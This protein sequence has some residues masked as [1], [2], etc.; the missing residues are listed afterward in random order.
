MRFAIC[1]ARRHSVDELMEVRDKKREKRGG[2]RDKVYW[3][4][5]EKRL[6]NLKRI[7]AKYLKNIL[8]LTLC[9]SLC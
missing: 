1:E 9:N 6:K 4:G 5:S 8:T 3:E 2:F 7:K